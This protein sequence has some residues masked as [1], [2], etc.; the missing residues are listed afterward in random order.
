LHEFAAADMNMFNILF[1][2]KSNQCI[3]MRT[4]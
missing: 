1:V 2:K 4:E 3:A